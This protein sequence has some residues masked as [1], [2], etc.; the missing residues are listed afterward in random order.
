MHPLR[1][2]Y[3]DHSLNMYK[4]CI[5][6]HWSYYWASHPLQDISSRRLK[7]IQGIWHAFWEQNQNVDQ[8]WFRF[9]G[10]LLDPDWLVAATVLS[11]RLCLFGRLTLGILQCSPEAL[12]DPI[13]SDAE[14]FDLTVHDCG[15]N[16]WMKI[17]S[18]QIWLKVA[19]VGWTSKSSKRSVPRV[20]CWN[21][22][23]P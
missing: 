15:W 1:F 5:D 9:N 8:R 7:T 18:R 11:R 16:F 3:T 19:C 4:F 2:F 10:L 21:L 22:E 20:E 12:P 6:Q 17:P 14:V 23:T 13:L